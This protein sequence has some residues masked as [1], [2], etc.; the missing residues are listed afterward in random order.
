MITR[1]DGMYLSKL[2]EKVIRISIQRDCAALYEG[3]ASNDFFQ[4]KEARIL[5]QLLS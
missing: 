5:R 2:Q 3:L 1:K 4:Y